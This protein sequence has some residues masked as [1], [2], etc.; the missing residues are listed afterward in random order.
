MARRLQR[1]PAHRGLRGEGRPVRFSTVYVGNL[2]ISDEKTGLS[3]AEKGIPILKKIYPREKK[4][5]PFF[6]A[7][8]L[9]GQK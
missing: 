7:E 4:S 5:M 9:F 6:H 3:E 8:P 1:P 2:Y